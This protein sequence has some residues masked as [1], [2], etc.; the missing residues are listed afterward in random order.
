M[1]IMQ[2]SLNIEFFSK[3][4]KSDISLTISVIAL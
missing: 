2:K 3:W 1:E 4:I